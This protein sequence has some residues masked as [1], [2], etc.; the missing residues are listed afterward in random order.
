MVR[1][2]RGQWFVCTSHGHPLPW[3]ETIT[4][5]EQSSGSELLVIA[6]NS[7]GRWENGHSTCIL[8]VLVVF[9]LEKI[10]PCY[11][12]RNCLLL[13]FR[14]MQLIEQILVVKQRRMVL[15][16]STD[17][18]GVKTF[19]W[20]RKI[21]NTWS[22]KACGNVI[23]NLPWRSTWTCRWDI[24]SS[25]YSPLLCTPLQCPHVMVEAAGQPKRLLSLLLPP[26]PHPLPLSPSSLRVCWGC[27][28]VMGREVSGGPAC[29][30]GAAELGGRAAGAGGWGGMPWGLRPLPPPPLSTSCQHH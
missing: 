4:R 5:S 19:S 16:R 15:K 6:G 23:G 22:R 21:R 28:S 1:V 17:T 3:D 11:K 30:A 20:D 18:M 12:E 2:R 7:V 9:C 24:T 26:L 29:P 10:F 13:A 14:L 8:L 25:I 27:W